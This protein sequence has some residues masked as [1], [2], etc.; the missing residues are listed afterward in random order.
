M[1]FIWVCF[2]IKQ[3]FHYLLKQKKNKKTWL[4]RQSERPP[5]AAGWSNYPA[6]YRCWESS[7]FAFLSPDFPKNTQIAAACGSDWHERAPRRSHWFI[8]LFWIRAN[9]HGNSTLITAQLLLFLSIVPEPT[10]AH[11]HCSVAALH[12]LLSSGTP[13]PPR[14]YFLLFKSRLVTL[15]HWQLQERFAAL[16]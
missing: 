16:F 11:T 1:L 5:R 15:L 9:K 14:V 3:Y 12:M 4:T 6:V 7:I 13:S 10:A 8:W 2:C